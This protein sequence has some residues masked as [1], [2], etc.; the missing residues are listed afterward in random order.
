MSGKR[1]AT[2]PTASGRRKFL[3]L[4]RA[5]FREEGKEERIRKALEALKKATV[6]YG[7]DADTVRWIAESPDLED[8]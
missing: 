6:D 4:K 2:L 5:H 1:S 3:A 8:L 7:L